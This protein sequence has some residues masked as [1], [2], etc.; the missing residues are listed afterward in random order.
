MPCPG[1]STSGWPGPVLDH[2]VWSLH[3]DVVHQIFLRF[4]FPQLDLFASKNNFKLPRWYSLN[5][6][7]NAEA[8]NAFSQEWSLYA[9]AFPPHVILRRV[10]EKVK[11]D[12]ATIILIAPYW[13]QSPW[14]SDLLHLLVDLPVILPIRQDL[15]QQQGLFHRDPKFWKLVAWKI[16]GN[17][18]EPEAFRSRLLT[19]CNQRGDQVRQNQ[20]RELE[21]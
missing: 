8:W 4:G 17:S 7:P 2:R 14:V 18:I 3:K 10:I 15:L 21:T 1:T 11:S 5:R 13:P 12:R 19:L 9:Y 16:S 20:F 6:D